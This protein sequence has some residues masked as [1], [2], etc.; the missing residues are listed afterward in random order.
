MTQDKTPDVSRRKFMK[1]AA[2][3]AGSAMA[4]A[5][6]PPAL[7]KA[8][9][10]TPP[11]GT[12]SNTINDV[13]HVVIFMQENRSFDHY[14]GTLKGIRGFGDR[15]LAPL[16]NGHNVLYQPTNTSGG[17]ILPF[18]MDTT[19]T[20]AICANA[21]AMSYPVDIGIWN[22]GRFDSWNTARAPGL[23]MGYFK[24]A[25][26]A[27][28]YALADAFTV[29]DAYH[30]STLTQTN[31]NRLH[32]F[33]GSNGLSVGTTAVLDNT[34]PAAGFAWTTYAER[35]QQAGV[36]WKV[37]QQTDN[38]DDNALAWFSNFK[39]AQPGNP[40]YD[41]GMATVPDLVQAFADDIANGTLP[42]VSWIVAPASLSE[43]ANYKPAVGEDLTARL[44]T[45]LAASPQVWA[46]TVFILN[47]DENG[48]FFDHM[49]PLVP[50]P[51]NSYGLS[52]VSVAGEVTG[53]KPIG[54]GFRVPMTIIS[55]WTQGGWVC[56]EV[57]D[58]TSVIRFLETRFGV[59]E[60]NISAWRRAVCGDLTSAFNFNLSNTNWPSLPDTSN[61]VAQADLQC[62]TLP[63]TTVPTTQSL[64]IQSTGSRPARAL[65]YVL[66]AD[67]RIDVAAGRFWIDFTNAGSAGAV[68]QV[69]AGN[70]SD[71]PWTYTVEAGKKLS[72]YW[73]AVHYSAGVYDLS[74]R[75]PNGYRR[76]F[77]G[78]VGTTHPLEV[79]LRPAAQG[80]GVTLSFINSGSQAVTA[81]VSNMAYG[82]TS[83]YTVQVP[84]H[85]TIQLNWADASGGGWYDI[86]VI[87]TQD[88]QFKRRFAGRVENGQSG[89]TDPAMGL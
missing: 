84:A 45:A 20:N 77:H 31:P 37:Y 30:C 49:P 22:K 69:Y 29:C 74:A 83:P 61:Y 71:G 81:T 54:L 7:R 32:L 35:L 67:G 11:A 89:I 13:Q 2:M 72:D 15:Q 66:Q 16:P 25:D 73:S 68:F 59:A 85:S 76:D 9:A 28:Y 79:Q 41:R 43:H 64:P 65:P 5:A 52:T 46:N 39:N 48:G 23:G 1:A 55:P 78:L 6:L 18:H 70:R 56:S 88:A 63:N 47:Y 33:S 27:F 40:L 12:A 80:S 38:F 86:Q 57:F 3:T 17:Y 34:E 82:S 14:L 10:A 21:A 62:S 50:P 19:T 26:L 51:S 42:Q 60:P 75:G 36:S 53:G 8:M 87:C 44:L 24:P 4:M 58:H